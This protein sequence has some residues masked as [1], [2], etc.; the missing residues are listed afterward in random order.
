MEQKIKQD[1]SIGQNVRRLRKNLHLTQ[2]EVVAR[3]Q[4]EGCQITRSTYA[5]IECGIASI[6][7]R[8]L[9]ALK[10]I[11]Q[12]DYAEFFKIAAGGAK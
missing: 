2:E 7:V 6:K 12:A 9:I 10:K 3:L 5:K 1:L 4:L 8:E 11:F